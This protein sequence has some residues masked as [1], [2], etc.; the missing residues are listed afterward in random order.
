MHLV[1]GDGDVGEGDA[2]TRREALAEV[3]PVAARHHPGRLP[4]DDEEQRRARAGFGGRHDGDVADGEAGG[5]ALA[6][7]Q[8]VTVAVLDELSAGS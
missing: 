2:A 1:G 5:E 7:R 4:R 3:V 8:P 6:A